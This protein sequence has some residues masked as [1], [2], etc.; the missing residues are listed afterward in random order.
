[1]KGRGFIVH[2]A[3]TSTLDGLPGE[4]RAAILGAAYARVRNLTDYAL[5]KK[6]A[7]FDF[8]VSGIVTE[9]EML[10]EKHSNVTQTRPS[11]K[12]GA[13]RTAEYRA[14]RMLRTKKSDVSDPCDGV[15]NV[16]NVTE[17]PAFGT[18]SPS[19]SGK[20]DECDECNECDAI[21]KE[22][23]KEVSVAHVTNV[24]D[25]ESSA[26]NRITE[27]DL[28]IAAHNLGVP[29]DFALGYFREEM[30]KLE[31]MARGNGGRMFRVTRMNLAS[32]LR[33]WWKQE[34]RKK[35][36]APASGSAPMDVPPSITQ[37]DLVS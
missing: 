18:D 2:S 1:M 9:A 29:L 27:M 4:I 37:D 22:V 16:T 23:S 3:L 33:G 25:H 35:N 21:S 36:S 28:R 6:L 34:E 17:L 13:Q 32:V 26:Q 5:P 8:L 19:E 31:W 7:L 30:G 12:T 14:R 24:T 15:T 10:C 11:A 20:C